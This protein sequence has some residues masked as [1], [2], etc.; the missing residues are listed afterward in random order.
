MAYFFNQI[1]S[2]QA[3]TIYIALV[4]CCLLWIAFKFFLTGSKSI[5]LLKAEI[6]LLS[7]NEYK[8]CI[9]EKQDEINDSEYIRFALLSVCE[10]LFLM[11]D[12]RKLDEHVNLINFVNKLANSTPENISAAFDSIKLKRNITTTH[13]SIIKN[14][15]NNSITLKSYY[16]GHGVRSFSL[17]TPKNCTHSFLMDCEIGLLSEITKKLSANDEYIE[18]FQKS[19]NVITD[20]IKKNGPILNARDNRILPNVAYNDGLSFLKKN[21]H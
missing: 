11:K 20:Y 4:C 18:I 10:L 13:S 12:E 1:L 21:N 8:V 3:N 5:P 7:E 9:L 16:A 17:L 14:N 15:K 6:S 19:L 2:V